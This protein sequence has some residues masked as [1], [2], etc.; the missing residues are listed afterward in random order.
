MEAIRSWGCTG[1]RLHTPLS[2]DQSGY[3]PHTIEKRRKLGSQIANAQGRMDPCW[4]ERERN[5][6]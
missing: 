3:Y 1:R 5:V 4:E 2:L 6:L